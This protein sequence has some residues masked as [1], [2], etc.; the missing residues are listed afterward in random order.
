M[1]DFDK[2]GG[3]VPA[4]IQDD[5]SGEVLMLGFMNALSYQETRRSGEAAAQG[6]ALSGWVLVAAGLFYGRSS[7]QSRVR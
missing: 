5:T 3:L 7:T 2:A 6:L 1:L 4:V